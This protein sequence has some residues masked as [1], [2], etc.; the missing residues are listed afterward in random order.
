MLRDNE[1]QDIYV[2]INTQNKEVVDFVSGD[3]KGIGFAILCLQKIVLE[4][5]EK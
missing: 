2:V 3:L 5:M 4:A 1:I